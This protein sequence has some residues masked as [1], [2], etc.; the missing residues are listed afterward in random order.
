MIE[1]DIAAV[2]RTLLSG[3]VP[4]SHVRPAVWAEENLIFGAGEPVPGPFRLGS[5]P[6]LSEV[7]DAWELVPGQ[8]L[9]VVTVVAP[10]QTGKTLSW[11]GGLLWSLEHDPG[12]SLVYYT[13]EDVAKKVNSSKMEPLLREIPRYRELLS[14]PRSHSAE[15]YRLAENTVY[16]GGVGSRIASF[17]ARRLI[18]DEL[19]DWLFPQGT[20]PFKDLQMRAR[21]FPEALLCAVCSPRGS[22]SRIWRLFKESSRGYYCLRCQGCGELSMRS[23]DIH[24]LQFSQTEEGRLIP[25]TLRLICPKCGRAHVEEEAPDMIRGGGYVHER[26][27]LIGSR[28]GFQWGALASLLSPQLR[29]EPIADAQLK[30]GKSGAVSD[31]IYFDNSIRARPYKPRLSMEQGEAALRRHAVDTPPPDKIR[32]RFW[33]A[34]TQNAGWYWL[35][36]GFTAD[37]SSYFLDCG[38]ARTFPELTAAYRGTYAG[39]SPVLGLIDE[40][41]FGPERIRDWARAQRGVLTYKGNSRIQGEKTYRMSS[42]VR[43]LLLVRES[44]Y[45]LLMLWTIYT[46]RPEGAGSW[47][48]P[49]KLPAQYITHLTAWHPAA[50]GVHK[51]EEFEHWQTTG[52]DHFYDCEKMMLALSDYFKAELLPRMFAPPKPVIVRS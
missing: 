10:Q 2:L 6:Y 4:R 24:N 29:W 19:D 17:S 45:H 48:L 3:I 28:P 34:D 51:F 43:N 38:M 11:L 46:Q 26:P 21:A 50:N 8:G 12:P 33:T 25:E 30:A 18:A 36:R 35:V 42:E 22:S 15:A 47:Y 27:E 40:G 23:C 5:S 9:K 41:G 49:H 20:D 14:L 1:G 7:L 39:G 37:F 44:Y 32:F 13:S 52:D 31:Q 16:F